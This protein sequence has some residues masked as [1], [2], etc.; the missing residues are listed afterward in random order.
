MK[1]F[2]I[3]MN[4][5][6]GALLVVSLTVNI[7]A[8]AGFRLTKGITYTPNTNVSQNANMSSQNT[9]QNNPQNAQPSNTNNQNNNANNQQSSTTNAT[10]FYQDE[11]V[12]VTY[13][14]EEESLFGPSFKFLIEN[15]GDKPITVNT[16]DVYIDGFKA[17]FSGLYCDDL[18][19]GAKAIETFTLMESEYEDFTTDPSKVE[20][21]IRL[22]N[23][24]SLLTM[25][26]SDRLFFD[27]K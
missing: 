5:I 25:Y 7:L 8:L 11:N 18:A 10:P 22:T 26:D 2:K 13:I 15:T 19:V 17:E 20:F 4:C 9:P 16:V 27:V 14:G 23:P 6:I 21:R 3:I 24:K 12:K 1:P